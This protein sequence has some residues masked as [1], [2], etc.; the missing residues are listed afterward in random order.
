[1]LICSCVSK[2][3][4]SLNDRKKGDPS[5]QTDRKR[6]RQKIEK[7]KGGKEEALISQELT[8]LRKVSNQENDDEAFIEKKI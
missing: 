1:M 7:K 8:V 6:E 4:C 5:R 3:E 2:V